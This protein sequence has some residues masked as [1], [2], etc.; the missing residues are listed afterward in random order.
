[1]PDRMHILDTGCPAF[2]GEES[3]EEKVTAIQ[4]Y[5]YMLMEEL[6]YLLRHLD[7]ENFTDAGL[8]ELA[9]GMTR[10][11]Q[12]DGEN[13]LNEFVFHTLSENLIN[14]DELELD[15]LSTSRRIRKYLLRDTTDDNY[16]SLSG[17]G[18]QLITGTIV[19]STGLLTEDELPLLTESGYRITEEVGNAATT[20]ATNRFGALLYWQREPV[21]H[22]QDGYPTDAD[23]Q[24]VYAATNPTNW[25]V[26]VYKYTE[27][28]KSEYAFDMVGQNYI[29]QVVLGAGDENGNSK[30]YI[31][32]DEMGF[33]LRYKSSEAKNV[34]IRFSD[35]GFV[36]A[37]HRRL[38]YIDIDT[39]NG[40][41]YYGL[42]GSNSLYRLSFTQSE[43]SATF[44]WPD[45]F[46]CEVS[47]V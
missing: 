25:P 27:L 16:V 2:T 20:Q 31:Y 1:M 10:A 24:P 39:E 37:M 3:T 5:L 19:S 12:Q 17:Q 46:Q 34:D 22:T 33:Y 28:V 42:E 7:A 29:P 23:G 45:G 32:K 15:R 9:E 8:G 47:V 18:E 26:L 40:E 14:N 4:N 35:D 30:G 44:T 36:D 13:P 43:S 6:R 21:G 11:A 38:S 41:V